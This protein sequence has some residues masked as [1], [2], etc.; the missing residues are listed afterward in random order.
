MQDLLV[1]SAQHPEPMNALADLYAST[2][3][4]A[5]EAR[6]P[7]MD[8]NVLRYYVV[9][10]D[11]RSSAVSRADSQALLDQVRKTYGIHCALLDIHS[12]DPDAPPPLEGPPDTRPSS[13]DT[14]WDPFLPPGYDGGKADMGERDAYH[15]RV[16][17]REL[18][19]MSLIPWMERNIQSWNESL[20]ASRRGFTGRLFSAG[21]RFLSSNAAKD[22]NH[23]HAYD[24]KRGCYPHMA[25]EAQT[26][27]L[28]DW[29]FV[30]RDYR[31]AGAMYEVARKEF[32][33]DRVWTDYAHACVSR[34][35]MFFKS[36]LRIF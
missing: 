2:S 13:F 11:V 36:S 35:P 6:Y 34:I 23:P 7:Y 17:L 33:T 27:K 9:L 24:H 3:P 31:L 29:A 12:W 5:V 15:I 14:L 30:L 20:A 1:T 18:V 22:P 16:F 4:A 25:N 10:H 32:T 8:P 28:A 21:R 19:I 26:R